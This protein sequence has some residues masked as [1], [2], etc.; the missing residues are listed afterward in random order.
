MSSTTTDTNNSS[1]DPPSP[2]KA[3]ETNVSASNSSRAKILGG[4]IGGS[5]FLVVLV[6]IF[7]LR[8]RLRV[9]QIDYRILIEQ[10]Q[11]FIL[12][13]LKSLYQ[14]TLVSEKNPR[15]SRKV[16][17]VSDHQVVGPMAGEQSINPEQP[18]TEPES[19][20]SDETST[21]GDNNR[22]RA[23]QAQIQL[24]MQRVERIEGVEEA[25]PEYVSTYG[26]G[27]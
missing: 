21:L 22:Y 5:R 14:I 2:T 20:E 19:S 11:S 9:R 25:P 15:L 24:L 13:H 26:S 10:R 6:V 23:M 17:Q 27:R 12:F 7:L 16:A 4:S 8:R 3:T 1:S 18:Q